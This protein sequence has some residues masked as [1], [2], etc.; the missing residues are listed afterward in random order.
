MLLSVSEHCLMYQ[1]LC[2]HAFAT[3]SFI[4][5]TFIFLYVGMDALDLEK[6]KFA[7]SRYPI[8]TAK[9]VNHVI[10]VVLLDFKN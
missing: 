9:E 5:E 3:L 1:L 7:S 8:Y 2:R 6:W 10:V 4:A